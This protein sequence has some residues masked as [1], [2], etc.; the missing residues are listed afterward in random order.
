MNNNI[1]I[2]I[3][4]LIAGATVS[5]ALL[6]FV[7]FESFSKLMSFISFFI[8]IHRV[9]KSG[10]YSSRFRS[11]LLFFIVQAAM[12][13]LLF[14]SNRYFGIFVFSLYLTKDI[15]RPLYVKIFREV[16]ISEFLTIVC[17]EFFKLNLVIE[18]LNQEYNR[19]L[20]FSIPVNCEE[21]F[22]YFDLHY[23]LR[24]EGRELPEAMKSILIEHNV[25][26]RDF[27]KMIK[28]LSSFYPVAKDRHLF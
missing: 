7:G 14:S 1:A 27:R 4:K 21:K 26:E 16:T 5:V 25:K 18:I 3:V 2:G 12:F 28:Y 20:I 13:Y 17:N 11:H 9:N 24:E 10:T 19:K 6:S 15:L 22:C 8:I 23:F